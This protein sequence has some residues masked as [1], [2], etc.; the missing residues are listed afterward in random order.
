MCRPA[1]GLQC[2]VEL[3]VCCFCILRPLNY[4]PNLCPY[5][6]SSSLLV[7]VR[8]VAQIKREKEFSKNLSN[9]PITAE[10]VLLVSVS[11][12]WESQASFCLQ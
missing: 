11:D 3:I 7:S 6:S 8:L 9:R 5:L 2:A 4:R 12:G 10:D 1:G